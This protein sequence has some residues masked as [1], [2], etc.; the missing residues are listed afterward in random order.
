MAQKYRC[1]VCGATHKTMPP[2]C[3][4]CGQQMGPEVTVGQAVQPHYAQDQRHGIGIFVLIA[5]LLVVG[6][7]GAFVALQVIPGSSSVEQ[8]ANKAGLNATPDGWSHFDDA[9][10]GYGMDLPDGTRQTTSQDGVYTT[11]ELIGAETHI[12]VTATRVAAPDDYAAQTKTT[13]NDP[14]I[15]VKRFV[16]A[17]ADDWEA[18][19]VASGGKVDKRDD[20]SA[21]AGLPAVYLEVRNVPDTYPDL[22]QDVRLQGRVMLFVNKGVL[23]TVRTTSVYDY[24]QQSQFDRV[25]SSFTI[26]GPPKT[27]APTTTAAPQ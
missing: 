23:Y 19:F 8:L 24:G 13:E 3:R 6:V 20:D 26:T 5:I 15:G 10:G 1:P 25:L 12:Q 9:D 18:T 22:R 17:Q 2:H 11:D 21:A 16:R 4:L 7:V 27:D 14:L